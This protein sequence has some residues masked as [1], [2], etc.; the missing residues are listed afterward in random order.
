MRRILDL[1]PLLC[2]KCGATMT[3]ISVLTDD[4][5]V[6]KIARHVQQ[7]QR[8]R[9][10]IGV[11]PRPAV[12][13]YNSLGHQARLWWAEE[14][15]WMA[16]QR[17]RRI[18][19]SREEWRAIVEKFETSGLSTREFCRQEGVGAESLRRWRKRLAA[20]A[21]ANFVDVLPATVVAGRS[22]WELDLEL[23]GGW[24]LRVRG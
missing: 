16:R 9:S 22:G 2:L 1:D 11:L 21:A 17:S 7:R 23:P 6:F 15:G 3:I 24:R 5:V 4:E 13:R 12:T 14:G 8:N 20:S 19:R 18:H 10:R